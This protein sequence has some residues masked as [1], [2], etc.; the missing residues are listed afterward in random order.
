[1]DSTA[2]FTEAALDWNIELGVLIRDRR[3]VANVVERRTLEVIAQNESSAG[4]AGFDSDMNTKNPAAYL[5][6]A[7]RELRLRVDV[8][9]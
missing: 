2:A 3:R 7:G 6:T 8:R 1:M 9:G 4:V 5:R